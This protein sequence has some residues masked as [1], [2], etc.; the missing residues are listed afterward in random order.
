MAEELAMKL[1]G[2]I[3]RQRQALGLTQHQV[4]DRLG[5]NPETISRFERGATVPSLQTLA[6]LAAALDSTLAGLIDG[7]S[8]TPDEL[9]RELAAVLR[10]LS[11]K[12]RVLLVGLLKQLG[13]RLNTG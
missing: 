8:T 6:G 5:V 13:Q 4:A 3:A 2:N 11:E 10:P 1:G 7:V 9:A 12:D